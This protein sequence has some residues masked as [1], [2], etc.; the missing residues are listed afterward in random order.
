MSRLWCGLTAEPCIKAGEPASD[1]IVRPMPV[2]LGIS[3]LLLYV[4]TSLAATHQS[5][6]LA[7]LSMAIWLMNELRRLPK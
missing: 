5:G 7:L 4:P 1:G 6:S 3:T 2:T